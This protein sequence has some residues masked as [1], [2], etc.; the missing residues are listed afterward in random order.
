MHAHSKHLHFLLGPSFLPVCVPV[1]KTSC[2]KHT[3]RGFFT[4]ECLD[5]HSRAHCRYTHNYAQPTVSLV[6]PSYTL[7]LVPLCPSHSL[8]NKHFHTHVN[9]PQHVVVLCHP[10]ALHVCV[11]S[12][13]CGACIA[14]TVVHCDT[15]MLSHCCVQCL[16]CLSHTCT[17]LCALHYACTMS[18]LLCHLFLGRT[19]SFS[20]FLA[21]HTSTVLLAHSV[22]HLSHVCVHTAQHI[23][24]NPAGY[25][26]PTHTLSTP[27]ISGCHPLPASARAWRLCG[28]C[29]PFSPQRGFSATS[30]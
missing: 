23:P 1:R 14:A 5:A 18:Q 10:A 17:H 25:F 27:T 15:H 9:S 26:S 22:P 21:A 4:Q 16:C 29:S 2:V 13:C 7:T 24:E 30:L 19:Y 6:C 11:C 8:L 20:P 12:V 28:V 3:H